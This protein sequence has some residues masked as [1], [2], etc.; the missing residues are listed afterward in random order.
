MEYHTSIFY[1]EINFDW[2]KIELKYQDEPTYILSTIQVPLHGKFKTRKLLTCPDPQYRIV[3]QCQ[4][5]VYVLNGHEIVQPN[6]KVLKELTDRTEYNINCSQSDIVEELIHVQ[7]DAIML[8]EYACKSRQSDQIINNSQSQN[9][10]MT[11][12]EVQIESG[13][14]SIEKSNVPIAKIIFT[15][16]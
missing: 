15:S 8:N 2:S 7:T 1:D 16:K 10:N 11:Q 14:Q 4:N 6:L 5:I 12:T 9:E 3:I 13:H